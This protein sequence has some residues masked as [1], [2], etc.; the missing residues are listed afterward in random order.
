MFDRKFIANHG[1]RRFEIVEDLPE[2][3]FYVYIYN[4]NGENTHDYLQDTLEMAKEFAYE[5]FAVPLDSW[6]EEEKQK[7]P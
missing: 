3:G 4:E 1:G 2:I 6:H 5:D 7:G